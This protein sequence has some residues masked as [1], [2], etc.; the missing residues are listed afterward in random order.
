M[1]KNIT[2]FTKDLRCE[3]LQAVSAVAPHNESPEM[4]V[5]PDD[6][7]VPSGVGIEQAGSS[8]S[9]QE[10]MML[11][12]GAD[13]AETGTTARIPKKIKRRVAVTERKKW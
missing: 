13:W 6:T 5:L 7:D 4:D 1:M 12:V 10:V 9:V 2:P 11:P 3:R 8:G